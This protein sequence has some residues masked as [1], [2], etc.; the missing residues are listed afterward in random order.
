MEH[1]LFG[2]PKT[3]LGKFLDQHIISQTL[4]YTWTKGKLSKSM[5]SKM[6]IEKDYTP[7]TDKVNIVLKALRK[8]VNSN[9]EYDDFFM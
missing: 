4:L 3:K 7:T 2:R 9:I 8:H 1:K 6:C 5:I